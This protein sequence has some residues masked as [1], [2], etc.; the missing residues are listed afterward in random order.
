MI[1]TDLWPSGCRRRYY[2]QLLL[3]MKN[4]RF[5]HFLSPMHSVLVYS[6]CI[7]CINLSHLIVSVLILRLLN[8]SWYLFQSVYSMGIEIIVNVWFN[9]HKLTS[10]SIIVWIKSCNI[11][12]WVTPLNE[13]LQFDWITT[14]TY[15]YTGNLIL[16]R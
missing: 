10:L 12:Y 8:I 13:I 14:D 16:T 3:C 4:R 6:N 7:R 11:N 2:L 9:K 15:N 1:V 5:R